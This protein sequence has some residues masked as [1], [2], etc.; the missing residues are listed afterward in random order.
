MQGPTGS[1]TFG[2]NI[3]VLPNGNYVITDQNYSEGGINNIGA[4]YLYNGSTNALISTL[5]GSTANDRVG[6]T[7]RTMS[8][9]NFVVGSP[10]WSNCSA[11]S[12]RAATFSNGVTGLNGAVS[13]SNS[14]VG[15]TANDGVGVNI[16]FLVNGNYVVSSPWWA[17]GSLP[18]GFEFCSSH[19]KTSS[20]LASPIF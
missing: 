8:N 13:S 6:T 16:S 2:S 19:E 20:I 1:G 11:I 15:S 3:T 12:A 4:V 18:Y 5:K 17:N 14:L 9:R 7:I 10:N